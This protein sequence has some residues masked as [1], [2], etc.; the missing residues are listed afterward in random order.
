MDSLWT[1]LAAEDAAKAYDAG[2]RLLS[3]PDTACAFLGQRLHAT[4]DEKE[5]I[6]GLIAVLNDDDFS[7]REAASND[8]RQFGLLAEPELRG[9]L[10]NNPPAE[11]R[12]PSKTC[13]TAWGP[14]RQRKNAGKSARCGCWSKSALSKLKRRWSGWQAV[15]QRH[16][17]RAR[18]NPPFRD[19][20]PKN[21]RRD[22]VCRKPK[23]SGNGRN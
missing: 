23:A 16:D 1:D 3:D 20:R 19:S 8:L 18:R 7:K 10:D 14:C 15:R 21:K 12:V 9:M 2:G 22:L 4:A 5:R 17:K 11:T 6:R 13:S